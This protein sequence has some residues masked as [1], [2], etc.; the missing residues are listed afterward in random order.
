[1]A[2]GLTDEE[3]QQTWFCYMRREHAPLEEEFRFEIPHSYSKEQ[4]TEKLLL[5]RKL[6]P[7]KNV[8]IRANRNGYREGIEV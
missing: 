5:L 3:I 4:A 7:D 1:M 8:M 2:M 6:T